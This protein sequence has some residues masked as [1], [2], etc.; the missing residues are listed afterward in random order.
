MT[1]RPVTLKVPTTLALALLAS[2][3]HQVATESSF[4]MDVWPKSS[5]G[6]YSGQWLEE[7]GIRR[8]DG[9]LAKGEDGDFCVAEMPS[10]WNPFKFEGQT[11]YSL[12]L[13][14][15]KSESL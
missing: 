13:S 7:K 15:G 12:P 11:Y 3:Q 2:C 6:E 10:D 1:K 14:Q 4:P 5:T 8:C 9:Y